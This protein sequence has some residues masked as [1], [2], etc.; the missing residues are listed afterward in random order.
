VTAKLDSVIRCEV[1]GVVR[2]RWTFGRMLRED[3][4]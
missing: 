2:L 3:G 1:I 4:C